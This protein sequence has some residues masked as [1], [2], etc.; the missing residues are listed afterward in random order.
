MK[1][2]KTN[3]ILTSASLL[4]ILATFDTARADDCSILPDLL[5]CF[6]DDD[7][8]VP[9]DDT[10]VDGWGFVE[11]GGEVDLINKDPVAVVAT[12]LSDASAAG[13]LFGGESDLAGS[14]VNDAPVSVLAESI[15]GSAWAYGVG[16]LTNQSLDLKFENRSRIQVSS[17]GKEYALAVG[18]VL[19]GYD[20]A[21][22]VTNKDSIVAIANA[23]GVESGVGTATAY[24]MALIASNANEVVVTNHGSI[25]ASAS[26]AVSVAVGLLHQGQTLSGVIQNDGWISAFA[27]G[28]SDGQADALGVVL[29]AY[30]ENDAHLI[31]TGVI[32]AMAV[33]GEDDL[34]S[35]AYATAVAVAALPRDGS[36]ENDGTATVT[37]SGGV[38]WADVGG[39]RGNAVSTLGGFVTNVSI[40]DGSFQYGEASNSVEIVLGGG[41]SG[42][43]AKSFVASNRLVS[44]EVLAAVGGLASYG[45]V[46]GNILITEDDRIEVVRG[47]TIFDGV[48]NDEFTPYGTL[49]ISSGGKLLMVQNEM[50]GPSRGYVDVLNID[51]TGTLAY[52]LTTDLADGAYSQLFTNA[53]IIEGGFEALYRAGLYA[54][55]FTYEDIIVSEEPIAGGGFGR[56]DDNSA[57]LLT[58]AELDEDRVHINVQRIAFDGVEGLTRNTSSVGSAIE[59]VYDSIKA[60]SD[61]GRLVASMFTLAEGDYQ[62][63][64]DQLTGAEY[65]EHLRSVLWSTRVVNGIISERMDCRCDTGQALGAGGVSIVPTADA[66]ADSEPGSPSFWARGIGRW[67]SSDGDSSAPGYDETQTG[68]LLGGDY[69]FKESWFFGLAGG[70]FNSQGDFEDWGGRDGTTI[71]YSGLQLAAYG[72]YDNN[73]AYVRGVASYGNYDG[74]SHRLITLRGSAIDPAGDPQSTTTAFYGEA[75]YRWSVA[76]NL[77]LTPYAGMSVSTASVDGFTES[78]PEGTGAALDVAGSDANSLVSVLGVRVG[79]KV[80][81]ASTIL[82]PRISVAWT[83]EFA[84]TTQEIDMSFAGAPAGADF[85]VVGSDVSRDGLL[86]DAGANMSLGGSFEAGIFYSGQFTAD[87]SSNAVSV[88]MAY[89]F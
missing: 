50:E 4:A 16:L 67:N 13:I 29:S 81:V 26:G 60:D 74:D 65:A 61:F 63:F 20:V 82:L 9:V 62:Q 83:H 43:A 18:T 39:Y 6:V 58:S 75:G 44:D 46:R 25:E 40:S 77:T 14:L 48:I 51:S 36:F 55:S 17:T 78:D 11:N 30:A 84:D 38:L 33:G 66:P 22:S 57:L 41:T 59:R 71:D 10:G 72:G 80:M 52:E 3:R 70:Y 37:N 54:D 47:L 53:A 64:L 79:S 31:N 32:S 69:S 27:S 19:R 49:D 87:Y 7:V 2:G 21:G 28:A 76:E 12:E 86:V 85:S 1:I 23:T 56:V 89:Q 8:S 73:T 42:S 24:G 68:F 15:D 5:I 45:Y 88:L 35:G 34:G